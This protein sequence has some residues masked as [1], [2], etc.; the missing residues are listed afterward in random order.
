MDKNKNDD[1]GQEAAVIGIVLNAPEELADLKAAV[2]PKHFHSPLYRDI[3]TAMLS[4]DTDGI[5]LNRMTLVERMVRDGLMPKDMPDPKGYVDRNIH[6]DTAEMEGLGV[7]TGMV[8]YIAQAIVDCHTKRAIGEIIES[9]HG[10]FVSKQGMSLA[11]MRT[12]FKKAYDVII[13][14][15]VSVAGKSGRDVAKDYYESLNKK[16]NT[17]STQYQGLDRGAEFVKSGLY[18]IAARSGEGKSTLVANLVARMQKAEVKTGVVTVE[19]SNVQMLN[20]MVGV[21]TGINRRQLQSGQLSPSQTTDRNEAVK[22]L[23]G[24]IWFSDQ[25]GQTVEM[26]VNQARAW[27][28]KH[29]IQVLFVDHLQ[30][31]KPTDPSIPRHQ[32]VGH[33]TWALKGLA[34]ELEIVVILAVQINREGAKEG[35]PKLHH[36]KESGSIEE[37]S[38]GVIAIYV[39]R[40]KN[41]MDSLN[42]TC[43]LWWLKNRH[44]AI[45]VCDIN[46]DKASGRM[47]EVLDRPFQ[48]R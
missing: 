39:D 40:A 4:L 12:Y 2:T 25:E 47:T 7:G 45:G 20:S 16:D 42:W 48:G 17:V 27:K 11:E 28:K 31:V 33:V 19:M 35:M 15:A 38:D 44:G 36:L 22:R 46:F 32:Q 26:I 10:R 37:D 14:N 34:R 3:Y 30:R 29:N 43:Q 8:A 41:E 18:T 13:D 6:S 1:W 24:G 23:A 21:V 5:E 9:T